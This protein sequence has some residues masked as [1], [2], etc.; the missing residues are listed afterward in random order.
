MKLIELVASGEQMDIKRNTMT[1]STEVESGEGVIFAANETGEYDMIIAA[2]I[3][4]GGKVNVVMKPI[5]APAKKY[6]VGDLVAYLA[7]DGKD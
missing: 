5:K 3:H 2:P 4:K 7:V 1:Y 6:N